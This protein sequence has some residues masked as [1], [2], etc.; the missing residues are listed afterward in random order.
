MY[1]GVGNMYEKDS[2]LEYLKK[3][4]IENVSIINFIESYS[5]NYIE[6]IGDS[7]LVKGISD[8]DWVYISSKSLQ[9]LEMIKSKLDAGDKN[10]AIIEDWMIP[11]IARQSRIRWKL[12]CMRLF[13]PEQVSLPE[14]RNNVKELTVQDSLFI[15]ESSDYKEYISISYIEERIKNGISSCIY[16]G[17]KP[18]AWA[19]TQ[20]DGAIGFL[21]VLPEYRRRGYGRDITVDIIR[22]VRAEG[23]VPFVHIEED[24]EKS[25]NLAM[26]LGYQKDRIVSWLEIE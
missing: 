16:D 26:S 14:D 4:E 9:E 12:S 5:V 24:N 7:V 25:M 2:I 17:G 8:R 1:M 6:R 20:D 22:K 15:Y 13:L 21:H 18:A 10:F 19:I 11:V 23:K 3:N